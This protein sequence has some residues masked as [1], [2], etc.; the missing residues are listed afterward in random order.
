MPIFSK[1]V[2]VIGKNDFQFTPKSDLKEFIKASILSI[3]SIIGDSTHLVFVGLVCRPCDCVHK[4]AH[5]FTK[6]KTRQISKCCSQKMRSD[7]CETFN[8]V[9]EAYSHDNFDGIQVQY[10]PPPSG[11]DTWKWDDGVHLS[12]QEHMKYIAHIAQSIK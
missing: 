5:D 1:V 10:I 3:R 11:V 12:D 6:T 8:S 4:I 9:L 7:W 2:V